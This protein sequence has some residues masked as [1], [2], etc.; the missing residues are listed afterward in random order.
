MNDERSGMNN[1]RQEETSRANNS[2]FSQ[3]R[4]FLFS[5][6]CYFVA[7]PSLCARAISYV[8]SIKTF[9]ICIQINKNSNLC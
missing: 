1:K 4:F 6:I 9:N 8:I 2:C 5:V 7:P 3:G